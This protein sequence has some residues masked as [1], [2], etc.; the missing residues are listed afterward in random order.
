MTKTR[1]SEHIDWR[2]ATPET[3]GTPERDPRKAY[4][5]WH[6]GDAV[7]KTQDFTQEELEAQI[8]RLE[9]QGGAVPPAF[10]AALAAFEAGGG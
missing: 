5:H 10:R 4:F 8:R 9:Q 3:G 6:D 7:V 2:I 1:P